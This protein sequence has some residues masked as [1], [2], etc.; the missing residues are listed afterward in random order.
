[1]SNFTGTAGTND[2]DVV[3][4]SPVLGSDYAE[5]IFRATAGVVTA[6][7]THDGAT[8]SPDVAFDD[9]Q[10]TAPGTLV[11]TTAGTSNFY[12][13]RGRFHRIRFLQAGATASN[14]A[15]IHL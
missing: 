11:A 2:N 1:M 15:G 5:H 9:L 7:V 8:W 3:Y 4:T 14:V 12:R 6:Q 10:S 13:L